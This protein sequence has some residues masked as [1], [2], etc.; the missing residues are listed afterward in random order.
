METSATIYIIIKGLSIFLQYSNAV[1]V[2]LQQK[3]SGQLHQ[4]DTSK[5]K[6]QSDFKM[7]SH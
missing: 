2:Y 5:A 4:K 3:A 1:D 6:Y 7:A